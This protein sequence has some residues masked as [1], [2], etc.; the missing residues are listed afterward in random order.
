MPP[1]NPNRRM[2]LTPLRAEYPK[3][4]GLMPHKEI[5]QTGEPQ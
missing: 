4:L 2:F 5:N 3:R 1:I